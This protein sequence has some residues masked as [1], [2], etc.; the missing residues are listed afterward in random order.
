MAISLD[1]INAELGSLT[2][3][4]GPSLKVAGDK[5]N[6]TGG[7]MRAALESTIKEL[8]Q[9]EGGMKGLTQE[10]DNAVENLEVTT[11]PIIGKMTEAMKE[12]VDAPELEPNFTKA[13]EVNNIIST[14][15]TTSVVSAAQPALDTAAEMLEDIFGSIDAKATSESLKQVLGKSE[16]EAKKA[17]EKLTTEDFKDE[18]DEI[19]EKVKSGDLQEETKAELEGF[20]NRLTKAL[21]GT[22]SGNLMK[23]IIEN[24]TGALKNSM[25]D[26]STVID[27]NFASQLKDQLFAGDI[28]KAL[29]SATGKLTVDQGLIDKFTE[30][31]ILLDKSSPDALKNSIKRLENIEGGLDDT[32]QASVTKL[33]TSLAKVENTIQNTSTN[34]SKT[35]QQT[36]PTVGLTSKTP[37]RPSDF[38][39]GTFPILNSHEELVKYFQTCAREVTTVIWHWTGN[40]NDQYHIGAREI[41]NIHKVFGFDGIGYHFVIKRD[42]TIQVGRNINRTGAH[43]K[44][45]NKNSIGVAFVAGYNCPSTTEHPIARK[46]LSAKSITQ[47]QYDSMDL[48]L[49]AGYQKWPGLESWGHADLPNN[50]GKVDPGFNVAAYTLNKFGQRNYSDPQRDGKTLSTSELLAFAEE[51]R[52]KI[53]T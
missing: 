42:G 16:E 34:V 51:A 8:E 10:V 29:N 52:A 31:G 40:Y 49:K 22:D 2:N 26:L 19:T 18:I 53:I 1:E 41:D 6:D 46:Y 23:D 48:F 17:L 13:S 15:D 4:I 45:F 20:K 44:G 36:D 5:L 39:P 12:F 3:R 32:L 25:A 47:A 50:N 27:N 28:T 37:T 14:I 11:A 35:V 38:V 7:R 9:E 24:K 21:G 33:K 30:T 43:A